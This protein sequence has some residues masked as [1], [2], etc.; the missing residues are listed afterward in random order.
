MVRQQLEL[1][2]IVSDRHSLFVLILSQDPPDLTRD[3]CDDSHFAQL[4][5]DQK[6][7]GLGKKG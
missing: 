2:S 4:A 3:R 6:D 7:L 1:G 5:L